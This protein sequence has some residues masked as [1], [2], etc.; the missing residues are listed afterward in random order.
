MVLFKGINDLIK[1]GKTTNDEFYLDEIFNVMIHSGLKV[2]VQE[3]N[4]YINWGDPEA[5]SEAWYWF[6]YFSGQK[7]NYRKKFEGINL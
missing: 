4:Y 6:E 5:M 7:M 2:G 1:S 3:L